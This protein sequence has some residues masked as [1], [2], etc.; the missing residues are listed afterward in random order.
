M[1][2]PCQHEF[3]GSCVNDK[4][5]TKSDTYT[6]HRGAEHG[7]L[8]HSLTQYFSLRYKEPGVT[9]HTCWTK[10]CTD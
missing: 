7:P 3:A 10:Q 9:A 6:Y 4:G 1:L 2:L 8:S 5:T